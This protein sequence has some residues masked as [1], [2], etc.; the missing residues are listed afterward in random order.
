MNNQAYYYNPQQHHQMMGGGQRVVGDDQSGSDS[1]EYESSSGYSGSS[2]SGTSG[3]ESLSDSQISS[4]SSDE[5]SDVSSSESD[6]DSGSG[7]GSE[8]ESES[9]CGSESG[10][11]PESESE[12]EPEPVKSSKKRGSTSS[13]LLKKD[14]K[15]E[16]KTESKKSLDETSRGGSKKAV[17]ESLK[18]E[19]KKAVRESPKK[20]SKKA[21]KERPKKE[22]KKAVKESPKEEPK[23]VTKKETKK[24][25]RKS[26]HRHSQR[27]EESSSEEEEETIE[28]ITSPPAMSPGQYIFGVITGVIETNDNKSFKGILSRTP[29]PIVLHYFHHIAQKALSMKNDGMEKVI[30]S[31][32]KKYNIISDVYIDA[33]RK[34]DKNMIG[35]VMDYFSQTVTAFKTAHEVNTE[36]LLKHFTPEFIAMNIIQSGNIDSYDSVISQFKKNDVVFSRGFH[37]VKPLI[38]SYFGIKSFFSNKKRYTFNREIVVLAICGGDTETL[39]YIVKKSKSKGV[40]DDVVLEARSC[41]PISPDMA[42]HL[43]SVYDAE[44]I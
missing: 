17:K 15:R 25:S 23:K 3:S 2:S 24:E 20:D 43:R 9:L 4:G 31:T 42:L 30:V 34:G 27:V 38:A 32:N 19:S 16:N 26:K 44:G 10:S 35:M 22:S 14:T 39:D 40:T 21:V 36:E 41:H 28:T 6:C 11:E 7:S 18:K 8:Y 1:D 12:P 29:L 13:V 5:G 37:S 33:F